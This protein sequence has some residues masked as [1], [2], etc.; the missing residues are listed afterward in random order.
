VDRRLEFN[1]LISGGY[2]RIAILGGIVSEGK[3]VDCDDGFRLL[4]SEQ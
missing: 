1:I 4:K 3:R 2:M